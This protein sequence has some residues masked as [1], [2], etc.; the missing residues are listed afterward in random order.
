[1]IDFRN[2]NHFYETLFQ[3]IEQKADVEFDPEALGAIIGFEVGGPIALRTA[4]HSKICVTSELAMY[5]EQVISA[6]GLQRYE[7]MTEGHFE[8]EVARTLLT[9][10]GAMSLSTMLGD[11]HTID[12]SAVTGSD[13][14][15]MVV[16]SLYAKIKF[17][18]S[19]YGIYRLS[20]A[21]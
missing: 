4:T 9:A 16:L 20:P 13:G 18:G 3:T 15:S 2:Q 19:S 5:P 6:E 10:V 21:I 14:P 1:M 11:G 17:E 8:L 12:V 7:L